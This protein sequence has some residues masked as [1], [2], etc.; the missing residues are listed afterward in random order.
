MTRLI[1]KKV[2]VAENATTVGFNGEVLGIPGTGIAIHD[3][4]TPGGVVIDN[5]PG[6]PGENLIRNGNFIVAQNG[7][8]WQSI[9]TSGNIEYIADGWYFHRG[10]NSTANAATSR[11]IAQDLPDAYTGLRV[12]TISG[13]LASSF[14]VISQQIANVQLVAG[15]AVTISFWAKTTSVRRIA[16]SIRQNYDSVKGAVE[17][18]AGNASLTTDWI[19]YSFTVNVPASVPADVIG[20]NSFTAIWIWL[21][22][23]SNYDNRTGSIGVQSGQ[24]DFANIKLEIG[25]IATDFGPHSYA[26][27]L[28][29]VKRYYE[30]STQVQFLARGAYS[31]ASKNAAAGYVKFETEK[32]ATPVVTVSGN[33]V[34]S[35]AAF[36]VGTSGFNVLG[37]PDNISSIARVTGYTANAEIEPY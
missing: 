14:S 25:E 1:P 15:K 35:L 29:K 36:S 22:A 9:P 28:L 3:G 31:N 26:D 7:T 30:K 13:D 5:R 19:K 37:V 11:S 27:E 6:T 17:T 4:V 24:T 21:E 10:G 8:S 34:T 20:A 2:S 12:T 18:F 23:G 33:Y 32:V 16:V